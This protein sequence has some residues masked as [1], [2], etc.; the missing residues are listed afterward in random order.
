MVE[1]EG[2]FLGQRPG[3]LFAP[4]RRQASGTPTS[5]LKLLELHVHLFVTPWCLKS[6]SNWKGSES[7]A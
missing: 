6:P 7:G 4:L 5:E 1:E 2:E 3:E